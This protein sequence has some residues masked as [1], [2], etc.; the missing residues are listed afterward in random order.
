MK[1]VGLIAHL[2]WL[3]ASGFL[4]RLKNFLSTATSPLVYWGNQRWRRGSSR[5][6]PVDW[7]TTTTILAG[8][9]ARENDAWAHFASRFRQPI[10]AFARKLGLSE[11]DAED[12]VQETL[13]AFAEQ[14]GAGQYDASKGRL[15]KWLFGIAYRQAQNHRRQLARHARV[16]PPNGGLSDVIDEQFTTQTWDEQWERAVLDQCLARVR[17]EVDADTYRAFELVTFDEKSPAEAA[18]ILG[19][20]IKM[21]Y[22]AK[23]RVLKRIR[24]LRQSIEEVA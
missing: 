1:T 8:L 22:N 19:S 10:L 16:Q 23:H 21:V 4:T 6:A 20:P 9:S 17:N 11:V 13:L 3:D 24:E 18:N 7:V 5:N 2:C 14:F 12:V 15:S